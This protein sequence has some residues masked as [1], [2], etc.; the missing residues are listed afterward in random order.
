VTSRRKRRRRRAAWSAGLLIAALGAP[1]WDRVATVPLVAA[2]VV[3]VPL[4]ARGGWQVI[5]LAWRPRR[6]RMLRRQAGAEKRTQ[7][8]GW[9]RKVTYAADRHRCLGCRRSPRRDGIALQW[10]HIIPWGFGG[11]TSLWNGGTLCAE[12]NRVKSNYWRS[13]SGKV[14]YRGFQLA[15]DASRAGQ[16]TRREMAARASVLRWVRAGIAYQAMR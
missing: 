4:A 6:R 15:T 3:F 8:P 2:G 1:G 10:D 9:M 7:P 16:I 13:D 14:Y 5:P 12:C 11:L